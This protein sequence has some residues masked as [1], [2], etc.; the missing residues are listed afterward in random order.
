M[1]GSGNKQTLTADGQITAVRVVGPTRVSLSGTF[2]GGTA[3][4][5]AKDPDGSFIDLVGMSYVG[6]ADETINFPPNAVNDVDVDISGSTTPVL[7][8]WIQDTGR[9]SAAP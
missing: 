6:A 8:V 5:R 3:K 9:G 2:G 1:A 4:I 7:V